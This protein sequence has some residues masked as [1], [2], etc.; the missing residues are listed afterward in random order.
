MEMSIFKTIGDIIASISKEETFDSA[1]KNSLKIITSQLNIDYA[2]L[3]YFSKED[4]LIH[5]Y[6][7]IC[8]FD[9]TSVSYEPGDGDIGNCYKNKKPVI[10]IDFDGELDAKLKNAFG[11]TKI[12]SVICTSFSSEELGDGCISYFKANEKV[13]DEVAEVCQI[14]TLYA[15]ETIKEKIPSK[16][17]EQKPLLMNVQNITKD[18][19]NGEIITKVLKGINFDVFNGEF[20]C[21]VGESGCGKSTLLN[22]IGGM[23]SPTSG[24]FTFNG[25]DYSKASEKELTDYRKNNIGFVFQNYNL[26]PNLTAKQNLDLIGELVKNPMN[27]EELLE[28]VNLS[29]KADYYPSQL[30]GGQQQRVSIARALVKNPAI[31]MA[32][33][34]TAALDYETSIEVLTALENVVKNGT[35][36]I[37]VTHNEEIAKMANRVIRFRNGKIYEVSINSNPL[38]AKELIW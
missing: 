25:V 31:I 28:L 34:P 16:K 19:K 38:K 7:W 2:V 32:D 6:Y 17:W 8:P 37:M 18:F 10:R 1:I 35:T 27:S 13:D 29:D 14:L 11:G 36:L 30:S 3:W 33:E 12:S 26:M 15:E 20:L 24:S 22:I 9:L 21:F 5:P 4:N 23:D